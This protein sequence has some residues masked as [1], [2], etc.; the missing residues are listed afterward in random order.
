MK[1]YIPLLLAF[2][3]I[4]YSACEQESY[5]KNATP[6]P[7]TD[8]AFAEDTIYVDYAP[9]AYAVSVTAKYSWE[10]K[11]NSDWVVVEKESGEVGTEELL[12]HV[13]Q[14]DTNVERKSGITLSNSE[15]GASA[16]LQVV[17]RPEVLQF[18]VADTS[19]LEFG[20]Q[21]GAQTVAVAANFDYDVEI[22]ADWV[23]C[24]KVKEGAKITLSANGESESRSAKVKIYSK[25]YK[26]DG[27]VITVKQGEFEPEFEVSEV[28]PLN[29]GYNGGSQVVPVVSN[30]DYDVEPTA[31]WITFERVSNGAKIKT[32]ANW[33]CEGRTA[34]VRIYSKKYNK[35][36]IVVTVN[37]DKFVPEF[38]ISEVAP[39]SYGYK[40][41]SQTVSLKSN[42]DYDVES[43]VD[44]IRFERVS[45]GAKIISAANGT[46]ESRSAEVRIYSKAYNI[47]GISVTVNQSA[48]ECHIGDVMTINKVEGV[49]YYIGDNKI[50][51][52]ALKQPSATQ[53]WSGK[54]VETSANDWYNGANNMA[55][56][57]K[58]SKW[59]SD[60]PAFKWCSDCGSGWYMPA[61]YELQELYNQKA[62]V[63]ELLQARGL[64][65]LGEWIWS[66]TECNHG[67]SYLQHFTNGE[68]R[69]FFKD[70]TNEVRAIY[71]YQ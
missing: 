30:F 71:S 67:Y 14:N 27:V 69:Y 41:G 55:V 18:E 48:C 5:F 32:A 56:I 40:G 60:Y 42:F 17:Q 21:G 44:W 3:V 47:E 25:N 57:K 26:L 46:Y 12:F 49:V 23:S 20:Y 51:L 34:E 64:D 43:A 50:S 59:T 65:K 63:D 39:L 9:D 16:T 29:F 45:G 19:S 28:Q 70:D 22:S 10:A 24:E 31:D 66:S 2:A 33:V 4:F 7:A 58:I 52:F 36:G 54:Y 61:Y 8:I 1:R 38:E 6:V 62:L 11:S 13:L 15:K 37:Q 53:K 68:W 35:E